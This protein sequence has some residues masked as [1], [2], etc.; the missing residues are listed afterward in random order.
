MIPEY[1]ATKSWGF[2]VSNDDHDKNI[3]RHFIWQNRSPNQQ[4]ASNMTAANM[5]VAYIPPWILSP[6]DFEQFVAT[7]GVRWSE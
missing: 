2:S 4:G 6:R 5:I 7:K 1:E 3:F